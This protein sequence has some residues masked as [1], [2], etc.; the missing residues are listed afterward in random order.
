MTETN[1]AGR[2]RVPGI[3]IITAMINFFSAFLSFFFII[4][5]VFGLFFGSMAEVY[6]AVN[7]Q[8]TQ[9][10]IPVTFGVQAFFLFFLFFGISFFAL[11]LSVGLGL[12]NGRRFAWY[13]QV[14]F[15]LLGL[16]GFPFWTVV[17]IVILVFF[18]QT[19][20]RDYFKV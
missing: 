20:I 2:P 18:F 4:I 8:L 5:G 16:M 6:Q 11:F 14:A 13:I 7:Q 10:Q 17:N 12:L 1:A 19:S 15:S 9:Q 3:I